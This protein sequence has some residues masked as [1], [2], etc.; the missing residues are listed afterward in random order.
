MCVTLSGCLRTT[1]GSVATD[2]HKILGQPEVKPV[3]D[4]FC[5]WAEPIYYSKNDTP[6]TV[7][8]IKLKH[9]VPYVTLCPKEPAHEADI[10]H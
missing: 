5:R 7:L 3:E 2:A 9:N 4:S 6:E 8:Q 1:T 10:P